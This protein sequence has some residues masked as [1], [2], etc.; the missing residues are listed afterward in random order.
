MSAVPEFAWTHPDPRTELETLFE[1]AP[2]AVVECRSQG[3]MTAL[4]PRLEPVLGGKFKA[5]RT[6]SLEEMFDPRDRDEG[7]R[8]LRELLAGER[9]SFALDC[10]AS[11]EGQKLRWTA[12]RVC[13]TSGQPDYALAI[14]QEQSANTLT[15]QRLRQAQKLE[16]VGRLAGGVAHDFNNLLTGVLLYCDLLMSSLE[17]ASSDPGGREAAESNS[18]VRK[19]AG[20]IRKAGLQATNMVRQLLAVARPS[21]CE[22]SFL[23]LNQVAEAMRTLLVRL[24][25]ENIELTFQLDPN[26]GLVKMDMAQAQQ[27]LLNLVLNA[28]D[29]MPGG[30]QIRVET[31]SC[32]VQVLTE[33]HRGSGGLTSLPCALFVVSDNGSGMDAATRSHLFEA[34]FTTK[35]E[36]K[37]TGLGLATVNDIVISNGGLIHVE[38]APARGTRVSVLL[39]VVPE[40]ALNSQLQRDMHPEPIEGELPANK[41]E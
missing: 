13:G 38:S 20:E 30:G 2:L 12:W 1:S 9:E 36:G 31:T 17:P 25:G 29:A 28:R 41:K 34:F 10:V 3:G 35:T 22:L 5:G 16:S 4:N 8:L 26:L 37:G 18:R 14:A 24:I 27:I 23:S 39:P 11:Q 15:E 32:Q 7:A 21:R 6:L 40:T 19:Y 33:N